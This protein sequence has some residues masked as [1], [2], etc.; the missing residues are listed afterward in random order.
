MVDY[1]LDCINDQLAGYYVIQ[2]KLS[3]LRLICEKQL[4]ELV[5]VLG[6]SF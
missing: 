6:M 1:L 4:S 5:P 3:Y 2:K